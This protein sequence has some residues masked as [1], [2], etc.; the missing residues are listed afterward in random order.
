M[1]YWRND[2]LYIER[3]LTIYCILVIHIYVLRSTSG[4]SSTKK[5]KRKRVATY[6][7]KLQKWHKYYESS[8]YVLCIIFLVIIHKIL[9]NEHNRKEQLNL[10]FT[11][12]R[13]SYWWFGMKWRW[14][15]FQF[16]QMCLWVNIHYILLYCFISQIIWTIKYEFVA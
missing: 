1:R 13:T 14:Q 10:C 5:R 6:S 3:T 16:H 12:K 7:I 8:A 4:D 15:N 2:L 11:E 9:V